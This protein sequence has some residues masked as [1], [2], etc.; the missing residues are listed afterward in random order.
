MRVEAGACLEWL[1]QENI[2]FNDANYQQ[3]LRVELATDATWMGWEITRFRSYCKGRTVF[4]G[5]LAI[6]Y[7]NLATR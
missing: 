7:R 5:K 2:I 3:D 6:A 1:P 4:A